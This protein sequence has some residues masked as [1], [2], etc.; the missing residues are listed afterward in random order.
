MN[1]ENRVVII[2]G[3]T[4]GLGRIAT[5]QFA[6]QGACLVLVGTSPEKL[7]HLVKELSLPKERIL[8]RAVD[9]SQPESAHTLAQDTLERFGQIDILLHLV[10][11]WSGGEPVT[12]TDDNQVES[13][14]QQHLWTT[15]HLAQAIIPAMAGNHWGRILVIS[16]PTASHPVAN[17]APYA[18]GNAAQEALILTI[19]QEVKER[20]IT[21]NILLVKQLMLDMRATK[22]QMTKT[23][24]GPRQRKLPQRSSVARNVA[25]QVYEFFKVFYERAH[26]LSTER[27]DCDCDACRRIFDLRLKAILHHGEAVFKTI[28]QFEEL[29]GEDVILTHKLL[30]NSTPSNEYI[31]RTESFHQLV[32]DFDDLPSETRLEACDYLGE[33]TVHVFYPQKYD[34]TETY[35]HSYFQ[36]F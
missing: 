21:A 5:N 36:M 34:Q 35:P 20:G 31:L 17:T 18:I 3:A 8:M 14:L 16:S 15:Y 32:G 7:Q 2:T 23:Q 11:G 19:A 28:H 10:G 25:R 9:L 1:V 30:K 4:G 12:E 24:A 22:S 13:M 26:A 29:A 6:E 33:V 27:S